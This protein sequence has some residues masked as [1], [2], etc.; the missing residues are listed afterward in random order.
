MAKD[1]LDG[2][3]Q[4]FGRRPSVGRRL[5]YVLFAMEVVA[6]ATFFFVRV[7]LVDVKTSPVTL[8]TSALLSTIILSMSYHNL[9]FAHAARIRRTATAPTKGAFKGQPDRFEKAKTRF[10]GRISSAAL[11]YS[12]AY[13]NALFML[14]AP[15]LG[16]YVLADKL[17]GDLN[18]LVS[19]AAA[20]SLAL[21]NSR[22][23]MKAIGE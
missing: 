2:L 4:D 14:V 10:E 8:A 18:L 11:W 1:D 13:N 21:S 15:F 6:A 9:A 20:A 22:S 23:A 17:S 5:L 7:F 16:L 12:C 19:G 3:M